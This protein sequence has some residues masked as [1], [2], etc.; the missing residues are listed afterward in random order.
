MAETLKIKDLPPESRPREVFMRSA[1]PVRDV[2]DAMLLA[3]LIRTGQKGSS[4]IDLAN[5]LI[6]HFGSAA[7][8]VDATWQQIVAAKVPGVGKVAAIQLAAAFALV[9][10]NART[11]QRSFKR[12]IVSSD[13]VVRQVLS[14]GIDEKQ[15]NVFALYLDT[16]GRLLCEPAL[17][18]R[19]VLNAAP[20]HPRDIFR[21]AIRLGA[22][23]VIVAHTH[24][25]GDATPSNEDLAE[26]KRLI[27]TGNLV[28]IPL[29]DHVVIGCGTRHHV[30]I[31][32]SGQIPFETYTTR[33]TVPGTEIAQGKSR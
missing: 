22:A 31:R 8:L 19:G 17:V 20:L 3:I 9:K 14:A 13:D 4:A 6:K 15:E 28:G 7:N 26:T 1:N 27:E 29:D 23:S 2:P 18:F 12:A 33:L 5:R 10:R 24:P 30:S 25:S 32:G 16:R 21:Q 11:S